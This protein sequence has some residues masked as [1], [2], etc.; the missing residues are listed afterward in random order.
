MFT[1]VLAAKRSCLH[2]DWSTLSCYQSLSF[3]Q[4]SC[5]ICYSDSFSFS[6]CCGWNLESLCV[7]FL[8]LPS[9]QQRDHSDQ[10]PSLKHYLLIRGSSITS[11]L[12]PPLYHTSSTHCWTF[13]SHFSSALL[14]QYSIT[15]PK[16]HLSPSK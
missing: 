1:I 2:F 6:Q 7:R 14:L 8:S 15:C 5:S 10:S 16:C 4:D 3:S 13:H 11:K 9:A 12:L